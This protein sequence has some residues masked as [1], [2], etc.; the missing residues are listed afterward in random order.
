MR[1]PLALMR[2]SPTGRVFIDVFDWYPSHLPPLERK[3][4]RKLD[5]CIL[6]FACLSFFAKYLDQTN[7][8]NG[9][10]SSVPGKRH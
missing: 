10:T 5:V 7:I 6:I 9:E 3:L 4:L 8:T 1:S 2:S